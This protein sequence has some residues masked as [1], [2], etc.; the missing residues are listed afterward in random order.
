MYGTISRMRAK[1]GMEGQLIQHLHDFEAA[2]VPGTVA[3]S[4]SRM[5]ADPQEYYVT[6][7]FESREAYRANAESAEQ[8]KRYRQMLSLLESEP[9]WHD[10]EVIYTLNQALFSAMKGSTVQSERSLL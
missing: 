3:V 1:P 7:I 5:D 9:E 8:D 10:G 2:H 4:C 6:V